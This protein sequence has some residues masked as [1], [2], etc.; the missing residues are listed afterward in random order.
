MKPAYMEIT[1]KVGFYLP[2]TWCLISLVIGIAF[3]DIAGTIFV[4]IAS[5][6]MFW[7]VNKIFQFILSLQESSG[8]LSNDSYLIALKFIWFG[9][10]IGFITS[11]INSLL[12][13]PAKTAFAHI[14]FSIFYFGFAL[15]A[16]RK[17]DSKYT[18]A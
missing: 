4:S 12:T 17:W 6:F 10:L 5:L 1:D 14:V 7:I 9:A 13:H 2:L 11:I 3:F 18:N 15:A 8:I 16:S